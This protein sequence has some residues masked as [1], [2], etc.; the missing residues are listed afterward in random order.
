MANKDGRIRKNITLGALVQI[1]L[2]EDQKSGRLTKGEVCELL[3]N[4]AKHPHG[5]KVRLKTGQIGRVQ[6]VLSSKKR[7]TGESPPPVTKKPKL[8]WEGW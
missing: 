6:K 1:V 2:K 5:I 4:A 3:T 7:V 8:P